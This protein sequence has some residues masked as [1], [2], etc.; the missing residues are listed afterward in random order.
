MG[1]TWTTPGVRS[2]KGNG[3]SCSGFKRFRS[4]PFFSVPA[5]SDMVI[6]CNV[7][8]IITVLF[9]IAGSL[10]A[11]YLGHLI[12]LYEAGQSGGFIGAII[13]AILILCIYC[14]IK[15]KQTPRLG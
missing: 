14:L 10:V 4:K 3:R 13:G 15:R 9:G 6:F 1:K 5:G 11:T 7:E 12:G 8:V 2:S